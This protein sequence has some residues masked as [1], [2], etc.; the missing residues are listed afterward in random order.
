MDDVRTGEG[1]LKPGKSASSGSNCT[2]ETIV[3]DVVRGLHQGLY[4]PGQRLVERDLMQA[5]GVSRGTVREAVKQLIAN[6]IA[7]YV[8]YRGAQIRR[9]TR[10]EAADVFSLIEVILGLAARQAARNI[11]REGAREGLI[12]CMDAIRTYTDSGDTFD[13]TRL[14]NRLFRKV[15]EISGNA[16]LATIIPRLQVHLVRNRLAVPKSR[17]VTGYAEITRQILAGSE[18]AAEAE[19][20]RYVRNV[21]NYT[22]P[23]FDEEFGVQKKTRLKQQDD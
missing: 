7:T 17:R 4:V 6:G 14:R 2:S 8:Q 19:T 21:A 3:R 22:L 18:D 10:R 23:Y 16:D 11:D 15:V 13:F 5:Y 12:A 20:R 9:L 1:A